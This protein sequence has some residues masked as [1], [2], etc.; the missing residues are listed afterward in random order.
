MTA[1]QVCLTSNTDRKSKAVNTLKILRKEK[2]SIENYFESH[3]MDIIEELFANLWDAQK[4]TELF[5]N[6]VEF[7]SDENTI[8]Y[9]TFMSS[10]DYVTVIYFKIIMNW[11]IK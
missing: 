11:K 6:D 3:S 5:E 9:K 10:L 4:F 2:P 7:V 1:T 8:D